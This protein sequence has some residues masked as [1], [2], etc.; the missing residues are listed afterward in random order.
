[1]VRVYDVYLAT[2]Q[3]HC[4]NMITTF[5]LSMFDGIFSGMLRVLPTSSGF[6]PEFHTAMQYFGGYAYAFDFMVNMTTMFQVIALVIL[7][8]GASLVWKLTRMVAGF[9]RGTQ[10]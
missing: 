7:F 4:Y 9:V 10:V 1:M 3:S 5:I 2:I 8:M 6:P